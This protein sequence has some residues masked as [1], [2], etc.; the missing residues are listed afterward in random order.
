MSKRYGWSK[1]VRVLHYLHGLPPVR[2]GGLV[3]YT[4]DLALAEQR[5]GNDVQ[6]LVPGKYKN[7]SRG[8]LKIISKVWKGFLCH[9]I[10]N[11]LPVTEGKRIDRVD[12]LLD[13]SFFDEFVLFLSGLSLDVIHIHSF[14]GLNIAFI[15]AANKLAV[16]VIFTTHDYYG[17]CPNI[18]L[19]ADGKVCRMNDWRKC[20]ICMEGSISE[21]KIKWVNS[22]I[23][24]ILKQNKVYHW[25]E[26]S[27]QI[28][29]FKVAVK[30]L[31]KK[32]EHK[33]H[34]SQRKCQSKTEICNSEFKKYE[35]LHEYYFKMFRGI[36]CF[37]Y[38]SQQ[39]KRIYESYLGNIRGEVIPITNSKIKDNRKIYVYK[40]KLEIG[41]LGNG[42]SFKG[43]GY[44]KKA[45]DN[46][47]YTGMTEFE[48]HIYFNLQNM[49]C[50]YLRRHAPYKENELEK[51]F[52]NMDVLV[53]PS[54]WQETFGMVV[55]E[56]LSYG[57]PVIIS[58]YVG[59][60][61][62]LEANP[63]MGIIIDPDQ[64]PDDLQE[65]LKK[66]YHERDILSKMNKKICNWKFEWDYN[67]HVK[68]MIDLYKSL[69]N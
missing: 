56:A 21:R 50:P 24:R 19:F 18:N 64:N 44:L 2:E 57:V 25:L 43:F 55:L 32:G 69:L 17:F 49:K 40:G 23:Y 51:V 66:I 47:Y 39:S 3:R 8:R 5:A 60:K 33:W 11:P 22:D 35:S 20:P 67:V 15:L 53:V 27:P 29:Y 34:N 4:L 46:L 36:T 42:Q 63:G 37:H 9:Y 16:P 30:N 48:C 45:L 41:Y 13:Q 62:L 7:S 1:G 12:L 31:I 26:Y 52:K 28:L 68:E 38:N 61:E 14:M 6:L 59:A 10:V 58:C 54:L 65:V